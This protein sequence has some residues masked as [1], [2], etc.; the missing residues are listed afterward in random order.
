MVWVGVMTV[1]CI[2]MCDGVG[3]C[4]RSSGLLSIVLGFYS[5]CTRHGCWVVHC[6]LYIAC[7]LFGISVSMP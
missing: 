5:Q 3:M 1:L 2:V 4:G 7:K 6:A